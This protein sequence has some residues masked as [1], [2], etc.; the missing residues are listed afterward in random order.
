HDSGARVVLG[1]D[2]H[3]VTAEAEAILA[4]KA[5]NLYQRGRQLVQVLQYAPDPDPARER[6]RRIRRSGG[7]PVVRALPAPILR[8]ELSRHVQ[9]VKRSDEGD[10]P[11]HV[12]GYA[13]STIAARGEWRN[14]RC[15][16]GVVSH[17]VLL[18]DGSI[19]ATPG[20]GADSGL[21]LWMPKG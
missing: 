15:L 6:K 21:L 8:D 10:I 5:R 4:A 12:P 7:A 18:P 3:R 11:A 1:T 9:F 2:E 16:E 14:L 13:V 17:A 20:Y 19:L